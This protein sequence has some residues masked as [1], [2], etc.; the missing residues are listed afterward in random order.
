MKGIVI[1]WFF[2]TIAIT[3]ASYI[4]SGIQ[5]DGLLSALMAAAFL[6]F[7]NIFF[8]PLLLIL[9][10]PL[11]VLTFGLFTFVINALLLMMASGVIAG[12][13]VRG[14]WAAVFGS[15]IISIINWIL[16]TMINERGRVEYIDLRKKND[17]TWE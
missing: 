7:L 5:V 4:I 16:S 12:F 9:T 11:N 1:R 2:L 8:R 17:D 6:G 3:S 10:L 14:F 15:L 13:H